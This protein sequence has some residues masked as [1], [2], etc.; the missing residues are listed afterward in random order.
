MDYTD[1]E[2]FPADEVFDYQNWR[3]DEKYLKIVKK[4]ENFDLMNNKNCYI[5]GPEFEIV[6]LHKYNSDEE[7]YKFCRMVPHSE[8]MHRIIVEPQE[9]YTPQLPAEQITG[10]IEQHFDVYTQG[11]VEQDR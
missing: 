7:V 6:L 8:D 3:L 4:E 2:I 5:M 1:E 9:K 10:S 11:E